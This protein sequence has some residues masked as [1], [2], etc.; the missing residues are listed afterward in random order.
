MLPF[1]SLGLG[2]CPSFVPNCTRTHSRSHTVQSAF[3]APCLLRPSCVAPT[4]LWVRSRSANP[5]LLWQQDPTV[6]TP[7]DPASPS[8]LLFH[9]SNT[10]SSSPPLLLYSPSLSSPPSFFIRSLPSCLLPQLSL[11]HLVPSL[12]AYLFPSRPFHLL[13][14][15]LPPLT[16]S[17][18]LMSSSPTRLLFAAPAP[19]PFPCNPGLNL[20]VCVWQGDML[21]LKADAFVCG[22]DGDIGASSLLCARVCVCVPEQT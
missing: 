13:F 21:T 16:V 6:V 5:L 3:C 19:S 17:P 1:R 20:R 10:P 7:A 22:S 4:P 2:E 12:P 8:K 9:F 14:V 18:A 11:I 15:L